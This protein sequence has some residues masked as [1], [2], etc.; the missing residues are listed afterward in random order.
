MT[1]HT[2]DVCGEDKME[3]LHLP[4]MGTSLPLLR[5]KWRKE[6]AVTRPRPGSG[7]T[8]SRTPTF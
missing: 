8:R 4:F 7:G 1:L 3:V 6:E 5:T 2:G